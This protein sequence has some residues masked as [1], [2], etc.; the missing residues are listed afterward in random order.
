MTSD[1]AEIVPFLPYVLQD[2]WALGSSPDDMTSLLLEYVPARER[3]RALDLGC[4]KGAIAV[5]LAKRLGMRV[6]GVDAM[7]EFIEFA[8]AA[9]L[10]HGVEALCTFDTGDIRDTVSV[11][12]GYDCTIYGAVGCALGSPERMLPLLKRTIRARGYILLDDAYVE[13]DEP[14]DDTLP[15]GVWLDLFD[16]NGLEVQAERPATAESRETYAQE[17]TWITQ[18]IEELRALHPERADLFDR[19]LAD[20]ISE[21]DALDT[22][23]IGTTWL[24]RAL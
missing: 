7:P 12:S 10:D 24:L 13:G 11:E 8:R 16:R 19:Y 20:Q 5:A 17:I 23:I 18:R 2:F 15:L 3:M 1:T 9:A 4:G 22:A 21:Y 14:I 6:K